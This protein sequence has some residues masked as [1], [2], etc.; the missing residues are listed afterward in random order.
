MALSKE[1]H[2]IISTVMDAGIPFRVTSTC[3]NGGGASYHD[4]Q[5][6]DGCGLA[7]DFAGDYNRI[8]AAFGTVESQLAELI[9]SG[10]PYNIKNGRRVQRYAVADHWDHVHVAVPLGTILK[11]KGPVVADDP[12][13]PNITAPVSFHPVVDSNGKCWGYYIFSAATAEVHAWGDPEH[14]PYYG[15]SEVLR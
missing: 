13:L 7:V 8:F 14:V 15:R 12:N 11:G 4:R 2:G 10:A 9:Y 1:V 6:T 3:R 5:G